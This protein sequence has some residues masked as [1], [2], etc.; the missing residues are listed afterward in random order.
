M[1]WIWARIGRGCPPSTPG[2]F[3]VIFGKSHFSSKISKNVAQIMETSTGRKTDF[4]W[5][6]IEIKKT[7]IATTRNSAVRWPPHLPYGAR[8]WKNVLWQKTS[9]L[10]AIAAYA[11]DS[12]ACTP[13]TSRID[14]F[15]KACFF[16]DWLHM[17]DGE[18][19]RPPKFESWR[20]ASFFMFMI[21]KKK[22]VFRPVDVSWFAGNVSRFLTENWILS[23]K[24]PGV[25]GSARGR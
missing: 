7:R 25:S 3:W 6:I 24:E 14:V 20:C 13:I 16:K 17:E 15:A 23:T 5:E 9:F 1:G 8:P 11:Q 12:C 19:I 18:V 4:F 21:S 22:T 10:L 2:H